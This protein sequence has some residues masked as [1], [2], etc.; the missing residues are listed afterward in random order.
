MAH[1]AFLKCI[2]SAKKA[3]PALQKVDV[4]FAIQV[5]G[6][7]ACETGEQVIPITYERWAIRE[8][9]GKTSGMG[10]APIVIYRPEFFGW[11][12][13][14]TL[15]GLETHLSP[16]G[17]CTLLAVGGART[18]L[19]EWRPEKK[20]VHGTFE[21]AEVSDVRVAPTGDLARLMS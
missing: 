5:E 8:D 19:G 20:G 4:G 6:A 14:F 3:Y 1:G 10:R 15:V 21:I 11:T 13:T 16:K 7:V 12:A 2:L 17:L 18:G 9:V